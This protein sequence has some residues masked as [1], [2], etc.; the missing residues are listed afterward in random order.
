MSVYGR[1]DSGKNL[2]L[3]H[4]CEE[5]LNGLYKGLKAKWRNYNAIKIEVVKI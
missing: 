1:D 5:L 4:K 2:F 3:T